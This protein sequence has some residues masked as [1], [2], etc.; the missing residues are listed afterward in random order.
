[1]RFLALIAVVP[2]AAVAAIVLIDGEDDSS[3]AV[4]P[5]PPPLTVVSSVVRD[6]TPDPPS[7][8]P[9]PSYPPP[10]LAPREGYAQG[11]GSPSPSFP[12]AQVRTGER[13]ELRDSPDGRVV[14][15]L[16]D[17]TEFGSVRR[18]WIEAVRGDWF[19]VPAPELPDG[20]L[21]WIRDDRTKLDVSQTPYSVDAD[22]SEQRIELRYGTKVLDRFPVTVGS[23]SSP[24]PLGA[25][26]V[27]DGLV[28]PGV[29]PWYGCCV[30]ALTGHQPNLP[31][32]WLGGDRIA[33]HGTPGGRL[34]RQPHTAVA[35]VGPGHDRPASPGCRSARRSSADA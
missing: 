33:I 11:Q 6:L 23:P 15:K 3:S 10:E 7:Q 17:Q 22:V 31:A 2:F 28:G 1:M 5:A 20:E 32:G 34:R 35:V 12:L 29:G 24:T 16:G 30:L 27:T 21:G 19:G 18:F 9:S 14:A 4:A 26:A 25:F 13:V 8:A